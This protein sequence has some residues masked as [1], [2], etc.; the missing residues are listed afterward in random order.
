MLPYYQCDEQPWSIRLI[1]LRRLPRFLV[2][3]FSDFFL[4]RRVLG[5]RAGTGNWLITLGRRLRCQVFG[6][7]I[8]L[9]VDN[10]EGEF[11]STFYPDAIL[12]QA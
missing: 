6:L 9:L 4:L 1:A 3:L 10:Q 5:V 8:T 11:L 7:H 12:S 2:W